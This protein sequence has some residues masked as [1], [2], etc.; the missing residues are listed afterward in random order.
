MTNT[1]MTFALLILLFF[2]GQICG[3]FNLAP[4]SAQCVEDHKQ[5]LLELKSNLQ[6]LN[7]S[8]PTKVT[9]WNETVDCC[10][11]GG[12]QCDFRGYVTGLDLSD[13]FITGGIDSI[14]RF[15]SLESLNL[16]YN[17]FSFVLPSDF[18]MLTNLRYLNLS[19]NNFMGQIPV[20]F[21]C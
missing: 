13:E 18:G 3:I 5:L 10:Q 4:V 21:L 1:K 9:Q 20:E 12:V 15:E 16:A 7:T 11:W 8:L 17:Y 19:Y 6:F 2:S 14:F